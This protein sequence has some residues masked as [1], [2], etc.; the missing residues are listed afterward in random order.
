MDYTMK[1]GLVEE[2]PPVDKGRYQR[3]VGKL[4][5]LSHTSPDIAFPMS[6][7]SQFMNNPNEEHMGAVLRIL[8]YLK[9]TLGKGICFKKSEDRGVRIFINAY[10]AGSAV[11]RRSTSG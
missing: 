11:D 7:D 10:W 8:R 9:M 6:S 1:L 5:Y 4:I 3:L 2:S